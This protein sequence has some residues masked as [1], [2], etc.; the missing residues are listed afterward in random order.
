[1]VSYLMNMFVKTS[2]K[3]VTRTR[4]EIEIL[5]IAFTVKNSEA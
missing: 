2:F 1:M 5:N 3:F 4:C